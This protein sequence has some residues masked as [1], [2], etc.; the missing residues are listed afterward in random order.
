M[1]WDADGN[2]GAN[3]IERLLWDNMTVYD[4]Y[5]TCCLLGLKIGH[6]GG[7]QTLMESIF[8]EYLLVIAEKRE[9]P[10]IQELTEKWES[11]VSC[12]L[13]ITKE[14][15]YIWGTLQDCKALYR[16][17]DRLITVVTEI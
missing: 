11:A 14:A 6:V 10:V 7:P 17:Q 4:L 5:N 16:A 3:A 12:T 1:C 8:D 9:A 15:P 13:E 2:P